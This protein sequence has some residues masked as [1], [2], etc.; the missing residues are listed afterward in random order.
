MKPALTFIGCF[1]LMLL[2]CYNKSH[3]INSDHIKIIQIVNYLTNN[4]TTMKTIYDNR[5]IGNIIGE[6]NQAVKEPSYFKEQYE[7]KV[8]YEDGVAKLVIGNGDRIKINGLTY[9]LNRQI[10]DIIN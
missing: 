4:K 8:I 1:V 5:K 7:L 2:S 9:K 3:L 6:L 10:G